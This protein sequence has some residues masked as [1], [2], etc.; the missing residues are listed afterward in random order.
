MIATHADRAEPARD[1]RG[2][3]RLGAPEAAPPSP[4]RAT[5]PNVPLSFAKAFALGAAAAPPS[6]LGRPVAARDSAAERGA[7]AAERSQ[8]GAPS[9]ADARLHTDGRADGYARALNADA[10]TLGSDVFIARAAWNPGTAA[11]HA[12]LAHELHHVRHGEPGMV[13]RKESTAAS[14]AGGAAAPESAVALD[15]LVA[16]ATPVI[17]AKV[18]RF[19][20]SIGPMCSLATEAG[21]RERDWLS[22]RGLAGRAVDAV[23]GSSAPD[24][25]R[26]NGV[27]EQWHQVL[28]ILRAVLAMEA[29]GERSATFAQAAE[30]AFADYA[31]A[32]TR[33]KATAREWEAYRSGFEE[34]SDRVVHG[35]EVA[36]VAGAAAALV[37]VALGGAAAVSAAPRLVLALSLLGAPEA[38]SVTGAGSTV[39]L[40]ESGAAAAPTVVG[41]TASTAAA[42]APAVAPAVVAAAPTAAPAAA[43]GLA[44]VAS[45]AA[46][47]STLALQPSAAASSTSTSEPGDPAEPREPKK[48]KEKDKDRGLPYTWTPRPVP[49]VISSGGILGALDFAARPPAPVQLHGHHPWPMFMGGP[50]AQPLTGVAGD[51]HL[52]EIHS[53]M[54]TEMRPA[55]PEMNTTRTR[56]E[57]FLDRVRKN[58]GY[59]DRVFKVFSAF[60]K[61]VAAKSDPPMPEAAWKPGL[62]TAVQWIAAGGR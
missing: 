17:R 37:L 4:E 60:Y 48:P 10:V 55:F 7:D 41:A 51:L 47:A 24:P 42:A 21:R 50:K 58:K 32:L 33:A 31:E 62:L 25:A 36:Q 56:S 28:D 22:G 57:P 2:R 61:V 15:A 54:I 8:R 30:A 40:L 19:R 46:S 1:R 34:S 43:P 38:A 23:S 29:S 16:Q 13:Y 3:D 5:G 49:S 44:T 27:V 9:P 14:P 18:L 39:V 20:E 26:W 35:L 45:L 53:D 12:L 6:P 59:R 11:T 52:G